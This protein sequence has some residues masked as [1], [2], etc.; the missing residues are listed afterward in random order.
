MPIIEKVI[1]IYNDYNF[2]KTLQLV[3]IIIT[4]FAKVIHNCNAYILNVI[5]TSLINSLSISAVLLGFGTDFLVINS[6]N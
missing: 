1:V 3:I 2:R 4:I 5:T 6:V